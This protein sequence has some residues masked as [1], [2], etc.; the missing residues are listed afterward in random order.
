MRRSEA[1]A[2]EARAWMRGSDWQG[3]RANRKGVQCDQEAC[4]GTSHAATKFS[5]SLGPLVSTAILVCKTCAQLQE[6][7]PKQYHRFLPKPHP[8]ENL[9]CEGLCRG[10]AWLDGRPSKPLK[11]G[12]FGFLCGSWRRQQSMDRGIS[13]SMSQNSEHSTRRTA[14]SHPCC[15]G[16]SAP[17]RSPFAMKHGVGPCSLL[18]FWDVL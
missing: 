2:S 8:N 4:I 15:Y 16:M 14:P 9:G 18:G 6:C 1:F 17:I 5:H 3:Q 7:P 13:R 10:W 11:H 12:L